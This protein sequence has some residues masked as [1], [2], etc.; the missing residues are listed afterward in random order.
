M[1]SFRRNL[2]LGFISSLVLLIIAAVAGIISINTLTESSERV[3]HTMKV[4]SQL[5]NILSLTKDAETG[6]RGYLLT[7]DKRFLEPFDNSVDDIEKEF[8]ELKQLVIDNEL[9]KNNAD[10]LEGL[11]NKRVNYLREQMN[12]LINDSSEMHTRLL[13]GKV[14]MDN[15]RN[16]IADM[17]DDEYE[18]LNNRDAKLKWFTNYTPLIIIITSLIS[19]IIT[20]LSFRKTLSEFDNRSVLEDELRR[21]DANINRRINMVQEVASRISAGDYSVRVE[22]N[23][24][25]GLG[26]LSLA[27]NQMAES[28]NSSFTELAEKEW[29]QTGITHLNDTMIG[30]Y[31]MQDLSRKVLDFIVDYTD[32][33]MANFYELND[34]KELVFHAGYGVSDETS[35][36]ILHHRSGL[37]YEAIRKNT[38]LHLQDIPKESIHV[39]LG[40]TKLIPNHILI[41][42][43]QHEKNVEG[44]LLI[45]S[46]KKYS[47]NTLKLFYEIRSNIGTVVKGI[48][49]RNKLQE[50]FEETQ[51]QAEELQAQHSELENINSELEAQTEK[52]QASEEELRVQQEE[53]IEVNE[54]LEERAKLLEEKNQLVFERNLEIQRKAEELEQSTRYKSEFLANMSHELRTPLNSILL[55]SRLLVENTSKNLTLEQIEYAQV[56]HGSGNGLL[57]L[58]DEILDLSKIEA[59]KMELFYQTFPVQDILEDMRLLFDPIAKEKGLKLEIELDDQLPSQL[60]TDKLRLEQIIKNLISNALK[61]TA[62][63]YVKLRASL[64]ENKPN[65]ISFSVKDTGIGIMPEKQEIIFEAFQQEDGSTRRKYGGTGL[66]LSISR[67]LAK[68]LKGEIELEST[69][70]E[71]SEFTV[72]IP[73]SKV[74]ADQITAIEDANSMS[75]KEKLEE[76]EISEDSILKNMRMRAQRVPVSIED[77]RDRINTDDKVILIVEDDTPFAKTLLNFTRQNG[78]KGIVSVSGDE[79]TKLAEQ[80]QPH[81]I[82]LDIQLPLKDGWEVIEE[83]KANPATKH[84]PVHMMSSNDMKHQSLSRGAINF[85]NKPISV[86]KIQD[87]FTQIE[88]FNSNKPDNVLIIEDNLQHAKALA[89][90]LESLDVNVRIVHSADEVKI[91]Q[92]LRDINCIVLDLD[93]PGQLTYQILDDLKNNVSLDHIPIII[94]TGKNISKTEELRLKQY[95]SSIV[96]KTAQSYQRVLDEVSLFLHLVAEKS[97]KTS[98]V[99]RNGKLKD[100]LQS[101]KVLIADDDVR[102][103]FSL[104]K[105]L[106][107]VDMD[108]VS[109]VNGKEALDILNARIDIDIVLMDM[110]MPEMDGYETTRRIRNIPRYK[111]I[112]VIAVTA[113]AMAGDREKCINAGASDYISKPVDIDQLLS[114]LRIWLYDSVK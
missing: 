13:T 61:F 56:I 69:P 27:I 5:D 31:K 73:L 101:K 71:G 25:D 70:G 22:D 29:L 49:N 65:H 45:G 2:N 59:G 95:S 30:E 26:N 44:V 100:V 105:A 91:E 64:S 83:L 39:S 37:L 12:F 48:K 85:V 98:K 103:I 68:L 23:E 24:E 33:V 102:N 46:V 79:A 11:V 80:Y 19:I 18:L 94:F 87:I 7:Y 93:S 96:I 111:R 17:K 35:E 51:A 113:K 4:I 76:S 32:S 58:I 106:E 67:E 21:K 6:Q 82:L 8:I 89:Y 38:V 114:L 1:R 110:M 3:N 14:Q 40:S 42:P 53:L 28:L 54:T 90:Y 97:D 104:T 20:I 15:I 107:S 66:G 41:I 77:D 72:T 50:L 92:Q 10:T 88:V 108:V 60:D 55:L 43:F 99:K 86:E 57:A 16:F 52:L 9:Q 84:I 74:I 36:L 34:N 75:L 109:A 47:E 63:G 112:P 81:G 62:E 78:Y